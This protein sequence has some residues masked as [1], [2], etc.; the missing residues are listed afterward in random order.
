[1]FLGNLY[2]KLIHAG[3]NAALTEHE[4]SRIMRLNKLY[5]L[6]VPACFMGAVWA[7][8]SFWFFF[9]SIATSFFMVI[10]LAFHHLKWYNFATVYAQV[11]FCFC[12]TL[13]AIL[14]NGKTGTE[15]YLFIGFLAIQMQYHLSTNKI[16]LFLNMFIFACLLIVKVANFYPHPHLPIPQYALV[17][18]VQNMFTIFFLLLYL[19]Y[20]Y[21]SLI[22]TYQGA[23]EKKNE[24][25]QQQKIALQA[26]NEVKN[27]LFTIIGHD[28]RRPI[29][30]I[31]G[32]LSIINTGA[33][34]QEKTS[35]YLQQLSQ[36]IDSTDLTLKNLLD[37]GT[38]K[39]K[40]AQ[41]EQLFIQKYIQQC[42]HLLQSAAQQKNVT[43]TT[44]VPEDCFVWA[45]AHHLAFILRNLLTNAI[46]FT[47]NGGAVHISS[48]SQKAHVCVRIEDNGVGIPQE[49]WN[50]IFDFHN[51][52]S[53]EGTAAE[54]GTGLGLPL[55]KQFVEANNGSIQLV[56][57]Q[58]NGC[59][60]EVCLPTQP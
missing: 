15:N 7:L 37:W 36:S 52:K 48:T 12:C 60:F 46:K 29:S 35:Q 34:S 49:K 14:F 11:V 53:T 56:Q 10:T 55:C 50:Q 33:I 27:R 32:L 59:I 43:I 45:D 24:V 25:L 57:K 26:S 22:F 21:R 42:L 4:Q 9:I 13:L 18:Y 3:V 38:Y 30:S 8:D 54:K 19:T 28:L 39:D 41:K 5:L 20:E 58:S 31:K 1:M 47:H 6:T 17:I 2:K 40:E 51:N 23:I 16:R 44:D